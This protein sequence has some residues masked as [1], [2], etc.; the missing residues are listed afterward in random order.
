MFYFVAST[1]DVLTSHRDPM[2]TKKPAR[3]GAGE[4]QNRPDTATGSETDG[5]QTFS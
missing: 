5:F 1:V 2:L 4:A 3:L